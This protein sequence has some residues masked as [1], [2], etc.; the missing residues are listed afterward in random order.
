MFRIQADTMGHLLTA[1]A[2][3]IGLL[4]MNESFVL[5]DIELEDDE[6]E[7]TADIQRKEVN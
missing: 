4:R 3:M 2:R 1:H 7:I 5:K 6:A